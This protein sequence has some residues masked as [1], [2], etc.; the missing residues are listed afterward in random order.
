[1]L[2]K[3][4]SYTAHMDTPPMDVSASKLAATVDPPFQDLSAQ[5][6]DQ[7]RRI[8][9]VRLSGQRAGHTLQATALVHEAYLKLQN[10]P[11]V[12]ANDRGHFFRVAAEA[13]RQILI[14]HAR[15]RG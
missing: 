3:K 5:V 6:Y 10:H 13:M 14:D 9:E 2:G 11:S 1:M 7:L 4:I 15:A 12:F 8:A